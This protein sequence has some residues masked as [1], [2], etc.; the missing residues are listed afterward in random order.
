MSFLHHHIL[1]LV[2]A[3]ITTFGLGVFVFLTE[4]TRRPNQIFG[5]YSLVISWWALTEAIVFGAPAQSIAS[6]W[7]YIEWPGVIL[8]APAFLH[9][10]WILTQ[11][12]GR[13]AK[14]VLRAAYLSSA[15]LIGLHLFFPG[16]VTAPPRP[17]AYIPFAN[18]ANTPL[19]WLLP[20]AFVIFV[21]I[22]FWQLA[23]SY[24]KATGPRKIQLKYLF[25]A[26]VVGYLGGSPN[27][28]LSFGLHVPFVSPFG[29]YAV[30]CYSI[31]MTYAVLRHRFFNV[32]LVI[33]RSLVYSL[34]ITG[35]TVGYFA[36]VYVVERLFQ[37]AFG[38]RSV[39]LSLAAFSVMALVFQP[40]KSGIQRLVDR[41]IF[42]VPRE[43]LV[44]R[45]ERYEVE[46]RQTERFKAV[47]TL[48]AGMAHEIKNPLATLKTFSVFLPE[49][50]GKPEFQ[51]TFQR[52]IPKEVDKIDRIVRGLLDFAKPAPPCLQ[53]ASLSQILDD[54]LDL[55]T[56]DCL[57]R[58]VKV[59]RTYEASDLIQADPQQLRQVFL[60]LLLNSLD[61]MDGHGGTLGVSTARRDGYLTATIADPGTGIPPEHLAR[62]GEPFFTT[63][64]TGTG[65]GLAIVQSIVKEHRGTVTFAS[66]SG[67][68]TRCTLRFPA[69]ADEP[70]G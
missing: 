6:L 23:R 57:R 52:L 50:F 54:M 30:P 25:W 5:F 16:L 12:E 59:E 1:A 53:P 58:R 14:L 20:L 13:T 3:A 39:W 60:N 65:L 36:L 49:R 44:R 24:R 70:V 34:L 10:V 33:R 32:R 7:A 51:Q 22:G 61:A 40:L 62:L 63:K 55:L 11:Q 46:V 21:N 43:E 56:N 41:L 2:L 19:G 37:T 31:A 17:L 8:I 45:L 68:G 48:A 66:R 67:E 28:F 26:S 18:N 29:I 9:T 15:V 35:L 38:Y 4:P 42:R 47:A 64:P 69:A 27:W